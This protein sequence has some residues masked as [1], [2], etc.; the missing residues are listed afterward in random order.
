MAYFWAWAGIFYLVWLT[1]QDYTRKMLVDDRKNYF[2][3][4]MS[5]AL[6]GFIKKPWWYMIGLLI[7]ALIL[8]YLFKKKKL[9]GEA[10]VNSFVWS[11]YGFGI[12]GLEVLL[13]YLGV[14]IVFTVFYEIIKRTLFKER[15]PMP[16]YGVILLAFV[17]VCLVY[18][19]LV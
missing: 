14:F 1:W 13:W 5:L 11:F 16:F 10:D 3:M 9:I 2:M 8:M 15:R 7:L 17:F 6:V 19:L 4:G 12:I 18:R